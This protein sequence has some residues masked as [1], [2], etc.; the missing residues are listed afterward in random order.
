MSLDVM[1]YGAPEDKECF[2]CGHVRP[3]KPCLFDRNITH[4]LTSMADK[5][6]I[7]KHLWRPE[8]LGIKTAKELIETLRLGLEK[9]QANPTYFSQFD[10]PNGW[11]RYEHLVAFVSDYLAACRVYPDAEVMVSR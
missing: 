1:L 6:G 9:L 10:A 8:E 7:Y 4:N 3:V 2:E 11:G 5:A